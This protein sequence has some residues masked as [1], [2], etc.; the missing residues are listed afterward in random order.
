MNKTEFKFVLG[1]VGIG[2][3]FVSIMCIKIINDL[4]Q[5]N[6]VEKSGEIVIAQIIDRDPG[7]NSFV[8]KYKVLDETYEKKI[9][10]T[11]NVYNKHSKDEKIEIRALMEQPNIITWEEN[12]LFQMSVFNLIL[13]IIGGTI[14]VVVF[15]LGVL[16]LFR[17]D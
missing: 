16:N 10:V 13:L 6:K 1:I 7:L 4:I 12:R 8:I 15:F 11:D 9:R 17:T 3:I 2:I 14:M 5:L